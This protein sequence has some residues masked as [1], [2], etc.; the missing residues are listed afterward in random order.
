MSYLC[1]DLKKRKKGKSKAS[2]RLP[3][4]YKVVLDFFR[5]NPRK[6]F[7]YKQI[8]HRLNLQS[9]EQKEEGDQH[10]ACDGGR[11]NYRAGFA[12]EI[13]VCTRFTAYLPES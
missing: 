13:P 2:R 8:T 10:F 7:N 4:N 6:S 5:G 1:S 3:G 12:W 9:A 11:R